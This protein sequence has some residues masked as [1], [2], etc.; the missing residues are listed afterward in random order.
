MIELLE[1][2][3]LHK[4]NMNDDLVPKVNGVSPCP[5]ASFHWKLG[6]GGVLN[7]F[8][9]SLL[10]SPRPPKPGFDTLPVL[11]SW[12]VASSACHPLYSCSKSARAIQHSFQTWK[13]LQETT[14]RAYTKG[15]SPEVQ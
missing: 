2:H 3:K 6:K 13:V 9:C 11:F 1:L 5:F 10:R 8:I 4:P 15:L 14:S 12:Q 7:C